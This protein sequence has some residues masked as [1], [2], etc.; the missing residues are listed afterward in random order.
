MRPDIT[1][2]VNDQPVSFDSL[3]TM[4][5]EGQITKE[6]IEQMM[7]DR[8][9][10]EA[11]MEIVLRELRNI[12]RKAK[13]S[14]DELSESFILPIIK[15]HIDEVRARHDI[16]KLHRYLDDVQANIMGDLNRFR[17]AEDQPQPAM[18]MAQAEEDRFTEYK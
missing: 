5:K 2:I 7:K 8:T 14:M 4:M 1:P 11:Q 18:P 12:E 16:D 3:D 9:V 6:R 13:G 17:P 10:L 15:Q